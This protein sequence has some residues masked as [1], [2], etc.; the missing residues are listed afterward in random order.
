MCRDVS[1][2]EIPR[3]QLGNLTTTKE[4]DDAYVGRFFDRDMITIHGYRFLKM[5]L[6]A[7][8]RYNHMQIVNCADEY[9]DKDKGN[10]ELFQD[11]G[12]AQ[13][14]RTTT[15][16]TSFFD[17]KF[18]NDHNFPRFLT[19]VMQY[20][21]YNFDQFK[22]TYALSPTFRKVADEVT[23]TPTGSPGSSDSTKQMLSASD[24]RLSPIS[25]V[26]VSFPATLNVPRSRNSQ[27][28]IR[29]AQA[30][31]H[32]LAAERE[33]D[34]STPI[35]DKSEIRHGGLQNTMQQDLQTAGEHTNSRRA[36]SSTDP[37]HPESTTPTRRQQHT[38]S[39]ELSAQ[40]IKEFVPNQPRG[41][42]QGQ[43]YSQGHSGPDPRFGHI[44][45]PLP[46]I[47]DVVPGQPSEYFGY[48]TNQLPRNDQPRQSNRGR[49][50]YGQGRGRGQGSGSFVVD[51]NSYQRMPADAVNF[52]QYRG[53]TQSTASERSANW[54]EKENENQ[55][56]D[57]HAS[58]D[59]AFPQPYG[60]RFIPPHQQMP[61]PAPGSGDMGAVFA[62]RTNSPAVM[63]RHAS[64]QRAGPN[65]GNRSVSNDPHSES[66]LDVAILNI[67]QSATGDR[68]VEKI[69]EF[70]NGKFKIQFSG[71]GFLVLR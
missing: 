23:T 53:R 28:P 1:D 24:G 62:N 5:A 52:P 60:P 13:Q 50:A 29:G 12:T 27:T 3:P 17:K 66:I 32:N 38:P 71:P 30:N 56:I 63:P 9:F 15:D 10:Q 26:E 20:I 45:H 64:S 58:P 21:Q 16:I 47:A 68:V 55:V 11:P 31:G 59:Q 51:P 37:S 40:R 36:N 44:T 25:E 39:R 54:R 49:G 22:Q 6:I 67:P 61:F 18:I 43:M 48:S 19:R 34:D 46:T 2:D 33:Q 14:M 57:G 4:E 41:P 69:K 7:I 65:Q 70:V 42:V 8:S 35:R